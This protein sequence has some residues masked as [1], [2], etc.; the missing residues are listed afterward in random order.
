MDIDLEKR[1]SL[2]KLGILATGTITGAA[3]VCYSIKDFF[4]PK[5]PKK[6]IN[7]ENIINTRNKEEN[8]I[9]SKKENG[10]ITNEI[11]E[12]KFINYIYN[13]WNWRKQDFKKAIST[14][15]FFRLEQIYYKYNNKTE[16]KEIKFVCE[17]YPLVKNKFYLEFTRTKIKKEFNLFDSDISYAD[18]IDYKD[19][20]IFNKTIYFSVINSELVRLLIHF[21]QKHKIDMKISTIIALIETNFGLEVSR[22]NPEKKA[23][24][25]MQTKKNAILEIES[26]NN[27][28]P[29]YFSLVDFSKKKE[30]EVEIGVL[31]IKKIIKKLKLNLKGDLLNNIDFYILLMCYNQGIKGILENSLDN[32]YPKEAIRYVKKAK[33]ILCYNWNFDSTSI[34]TT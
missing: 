1:K 24:G 25:I 33:A 14:K 34:K 2:K 26:E 12:R 9:I 3:G 17:I 13:N 7:S 5:S 11:S 32:E 29:P 6:T 8:K 21:C 22:E 10:G 23:I 31:Y 28:Y 27:L 20:V 16:I 4:K 15:D 30:R 18:F 19:K